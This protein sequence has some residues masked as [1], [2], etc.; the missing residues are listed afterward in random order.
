MSGANVSPL[1]RNNRTMMIFKKAIPRRLFLRGAGASLAL[2]LLD[3][4]VPALAASTSAAA[5]PASRVAFVYVPNGIIMD[6]WTPAKEG[7]AF[8]LSPTLAPLAPFRDQLLV[9][10]GLAQ[11]EALAKQGE[12][13]GQHSRAS[14][15][16]LTGM[17]P[18]RTEGSDIHAGIS[19]D[20]LIAKEFGKYTQ[21]ASLEVALDRTAVVGTCDTG[22]SCAYSNTMCWRTPTNP[23]PMENQPRAV[24]ERLFGDSD[25]T[26]SAQRIAQIRNDR[27]LLDSVA[28]QVSR[29]LTGLGPGDRNKLNEYLDAIR[30]VERRIQTAEQQSS[31]ELPAVE[32]PVA[33]PT[34][35]SDYCKLMVDLQVLAYQTDLT[36]VLTFMMAREQST[37]VYDELGFADPHHPLTHHQHDA[38]KINKV[39]QIDLLHVKMLAY[40]VD[41]LKSTA[42]GDG[43]LLDH[44]MI[45]YGSCISD[46]NMHTFDD[47][48]VLLIGGGGGQIKAG[49]HLRYA[50]NTPMTN[51]FLTML[52]KL[53][54]PTENF[55]DSTGRLDLS[56]A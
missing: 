4:M 17:H 36:R 47:L 39:A 43:S 48:P 56:I 51:L 55:G 31:R 38:T 12:S 9:L 2:P 34:K 46:G 37:L 21:L 16:F 7:A 35:Y 8:D 32:R 6:R 27:S 22:Y 54:M 13:G 1:G 11:N 42:D 53:E 25:T 18:K 19:I 33:V 52:D 14:A 30:D 28:Q 44:S 24:F 15:V 45:V 40:F 50:K 5:K 3:A 26:D 49:R 29:I 41:R 23:V 20:Q 10:T